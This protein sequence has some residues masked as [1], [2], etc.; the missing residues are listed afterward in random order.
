MD[1]G[2]KNLKCTNT[3]Q[4]FGDAMDA[5][6]AMLGEDRRSYSDR[7]LTMD[8][9]KTGDE[10]EWK[11]EFADMKDADGNSYVDYQHVYYVCD[12]DKVAAGEE[13]T[14][15]C[16]KVKITKT[17]HSDDPDKKCF[18]NALNVFL[19]LTAVIIGY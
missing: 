12:F 14:A 15:D 16:G 2:V 6:D 5:Y 4:S 19:A 10:K 8:Y 18:S 1:D 17:K 7:T 9:G 11:E 13:T 3:D